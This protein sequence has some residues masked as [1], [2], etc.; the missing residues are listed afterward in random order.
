MEGEYTLW[1]NAAR[2]RY[3]RLDGMDG[4]ADDGLDGWADDGLHCGA[5]FDALIG[6]RWVPVRLEYSD[7]NEQY[8]L[9]RG[10]YLCDG[11]GAGDPLNARFLHQNS[12]EFMPT[13]KLFIHCNGLPRISDDALFASGRIRVLPFDRTFTD[14]E[15]DK[16]LVTQ[17]SQP[18][19]MAGI[20]N[21]C[22]EG[23]RM[24]AAQGLHE[25]LAVQQATSKYRMENDYFR[26][27]LD[28]HFDPNGQGT[29]TVREMRMVYEMW[30]NRNGAKPF[31]LKAFISELESH[32]LEVIMNAHAHQKTVAGKLYPDGVL[33][34]VPSA[35]TG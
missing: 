31:G 3:G 10:W 20:L 18:D 22:L 15:Q 34:S 16:T 12:F 2:E 23:A 1:Y 29:T 35:E 17:F 14:A 33:Y 24:Y 32:G 25:P 27:F 6:D 19:S 7:W 4:W 13:F 30:C 11:S 21:W 26:Q 8:A 9:A 5:C 28:E